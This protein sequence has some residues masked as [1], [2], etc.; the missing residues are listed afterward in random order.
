MKELCI[1]SRLLHVL[2]PS[3]LSRLH[4]IQDIKEA[5]WG[6]INWQKGNFTKKEAP[7][8]INS[9]KLSTGRLSFPN[10]W[11]IATVSW[12]ASFLA[13]ISPTLIYLVSIDYCL[14]LI[15]T[16]VIF[17]LILC[18][19]CLIYLRKRS[20][21]PKRYFVHEPSY[22]TPAHIHLCPNSSRPHCFHHSL[23]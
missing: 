15:L 6:I 1:H 2:F 12:W 16:S 23:Q 22:I 13:R 14:V 7:Q 9:L 10:V 18:L 8:A 11:I 17:K 21:Q 4:D 19:E 3:L 20:T 5:C